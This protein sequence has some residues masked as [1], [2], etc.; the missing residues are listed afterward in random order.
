MEEGYGYLGVEVVSVRIEL[1]MTA[2][3]VKVDGVTAGVCVGVR[4]GC[5]CGGAEGA[6]LHLCGDD[7]L[8]RIVTL[9]EA[10]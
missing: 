5:L 10:R 4:P 8:V 6:L 1:W 3:V 9:C 7:F 2:V